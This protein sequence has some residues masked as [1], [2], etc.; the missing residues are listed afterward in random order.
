[1]TGLEKKISDA[2]NK[3]VLHVITSGDWIKPTY[4]DR[5]PIPQEFIQEAW[6]LVDQDKV[7]SQIAKRIEE[8]LA[9]KIINHMA[10]E[11]G[12]DIKKVLSI[13]ERREAIRSLVRENINEIC[14]T[15]TNEKE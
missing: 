10:A 9:N 4:K 7:K 13:T 2:A 12:S 15:P 8:E 5:V 14:R 11:I 3:A 1:M 6:Q